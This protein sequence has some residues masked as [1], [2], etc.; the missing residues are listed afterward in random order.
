MR[1]FT[2]P[3]ITTLSLACIAALAAPQRAPARDVNPLDPLDWVQEQEITADLGF[4][5]RAGFA[6]GVSPWTY[7]LDQ[8]PLIVHYLRLAVWPTGLL[9]DYGEPTART[10][11][12]VWPSAA[13]VSS[14]SRNERSLEE[15]CACC[16]G[17]RFST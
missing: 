11:G 1:G 10:L 6:S 5:A 8:A 4:F 2:F 9:F 3:G 16:P 13:A 17:T 14:D 12:E 7:L 15:P